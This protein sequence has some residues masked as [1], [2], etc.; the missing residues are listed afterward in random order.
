MRV[1]KGALLFGLGLLAGCGVNDVP[2]AGGVVKSEG[3][4]PSGAFAAQ[5]RPGPNDPGHGH[6]TSLSVFD[7]GSGKKIRDLVHLTDRAPARLAGPSRTRD[8]SVVYG[9]AYGGHDPNSG[10][11]KPGSC[12]GTVYR[13]DGSTGNVRSLFTVANDRTLDAPA[14][15]PDGKAV[16]YLSQGCTDVFGAQVVVH[17]LATDRER[18]VSVTDGTVGRVD[19]R[20][21]GKALV[22]AVADRT[23]PTGYLVVPADANGPQSL[24]AALPAPDAGC[25]V[26]AAAFSDAGVAL[27]EGCP[28][29]A[30]VPARLLQLSGTG[31]SVVWRADTGLCPTGMTLAHDQAGALLVAG[32]TTCGGASPI[33]VVSLWTGPSPRELGR[34]DPGIQ[35]VRT[36]G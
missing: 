25:V 31:P 14:V 27:L 18:T 36:A 33:D 20:A 5:F 9:L 16:A 13:V 11:P 28:D 10:A 30:A 15:S 17:D 19:W 22:F 34:Y 24:S 12:G 23:K 8:G 6:G 2:N 26:A 32:T 1:P 21:D 4:L 3:P 7:E 35:S 29:T